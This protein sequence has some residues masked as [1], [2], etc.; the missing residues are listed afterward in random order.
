MGA[1]KYPGQAN[2]VVQNAAVVG[3]GLLCKVKA[4]RPLPRKCGS[5]RLHAYAQSEVYSRVVSASDIRLLYPASRSAM[6]VLV[7]DW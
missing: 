1:H 5:F 4:R 3:E 7:Q 6:A 2:L